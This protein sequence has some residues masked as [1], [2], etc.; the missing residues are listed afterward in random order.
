MTKAYKPDHQG[1]REL[2]MSAEV[3]AAMVQAAEVGRRW[4]ESVAPVKT[5]RYKSEF[6][7]EPTTV[8]AGYDNEDRAGA[9]LIN[10]APHAHLVEDVHHV[11]AR[12]VDVIENGE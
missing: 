10:N 1:M 12:A 9:A 8:Q 5:G 4:A 3:G 2:G 11:L 7:V 6:R